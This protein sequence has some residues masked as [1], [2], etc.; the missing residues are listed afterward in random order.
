M[1]K[2]QHPELTYHQIDSIQDAL[3]RLVIAVE[4]VQPVEVVQYR[5]DQQSDTNPSITREIGE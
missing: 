2:H 5:Q 4:N 1:N 3:E